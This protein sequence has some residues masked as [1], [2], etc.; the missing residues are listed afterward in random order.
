M[1]EL[2]RQTEDETKAAEVAAKSRAKR[3][4]GR[5]FRGSGSGS[6]AISCLH[7]EQGFLPG[8]TRPARRFSQ[9]DYLTVWPDAGS[10]ALAGLRLIASVA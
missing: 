10:L 9:S 6:G 2:L 7:L 3:C 4:S 5:N 8:H 1:G